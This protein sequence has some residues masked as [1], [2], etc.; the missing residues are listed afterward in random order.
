MA[1][2]KVGDRVICTERSTVGFPGVVGE[3]YIVERVVG[4]CIVLEGRGSL[5][6]YE[7]RF[8]LVEKKA[9]EAAAKPSFKPGDRVRLVEDYSLAKA[10]AMATVGPRGMF[11][12]FVDIKFDRNGHD[13]GMPDGGYYPHQF[14]LVSRPWPEKWPDASIAPFAPASP[15]TQATP[16]T[17]QLVSVQIDAIDEEYGPVVTAATTSPAIV[18]LMKNGRPLPAKEPFVHANP[19]AASKEAGRLAK[20][21]RGEE[22]AVYVLA[23][24]RKDDPPTAKFKIGEHVSVRRAFGRVDRIKTA[25]FINGRWG[26]TLHK[27][28]GF[29]F[30]DDIGEV[31][32][33]HEWQRL[34]QTGQR[35][36]AIRII[37]E[38]TGLPLE[39]ARLAVNSWADAMMIGRI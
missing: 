38:K 35:G 26:Y 36:A 25:A 30:D 27:M 6:C 37:H 15:A 39:Y 17:R 10:G 13:G 7:N 4:D 21:H 14:I 23:A 11:G 2:F 12:E 32:C 3:E 19:V 16:T 1:K 31:K 33:E 29:Y 24:T 28:K 18:C 5:K 20:K 8:K 34:A 9:E 22:F